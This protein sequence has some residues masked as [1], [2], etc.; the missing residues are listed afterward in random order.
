MKTPIGGFFGLSVAESLAAPASVH[1]G[2][3]ALNTGRACMRVILQQLRP[4]AVWIPFY[5]CDSLETAFRAEGVAYRFYYLNDN[6][7]PLENIQLEAGEY[8]LYINYFGLQQ[9]NIDHLYE[10]YGNR[11]IIDNVQSFFDGPY[12]DCCSFNSARKF[13]GVPDGAYLYS[14]QGNLPA[15]FATAG[16]PDI[17][18]LVYRA[19]GDHGKA[20]TMYR[21]HEEEMT[22]EV[23]QIS[24]LSAAILSRTDGNLCMRSRKENFAI[25]HE[26][27]KGIN[28]FP[29]LD[30]A[31]EE[32]VPFFYPL[33]P[34]RQISR[35]ELVARQ[36]FIPHFWPERQAEQARGFDAQVLKALLPLPVDQR[37]GREEMNEIVKLCKYEYSR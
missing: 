33:L 29:G 17:E 31:P 37:Y 34:D 28:R 7:L 9:R 4:S 22:S 11:L 6:L 32:A 10:M 8:L 18:Y 20:Y 5:S 13:F 30:A 12:K 24:A 36:L 23:R 35:Q 14:P 1:P 21:L 25:L 2:A 19:I 16:N 3:I 15:V 26:E 27:L